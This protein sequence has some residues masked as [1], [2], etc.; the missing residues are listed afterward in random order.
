MARRGLWTPWRVVIVILVIALSLA[1]LAIPQEQMEA[2]QEYGYLGAFLISLLANATI[3]IPAPAIVIIFAMGAHLSPVW[4]GLA[5]GS[6]AA[7]G[8]LSGYLA[9]LSGQAIVEDNATYRRL[10]AWVKRYGG[11]AIFG[12]AAIPNPFF[13]LGGISAGAL[14]MPVLR[15]LLWCAAGKSLRMFVV[16]LAGAGLL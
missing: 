6:G 11:L 1:I 14:R 12:L 16:A 8:E 9:G 10:S 4:L 3:V 7:I 5:A 13:D 2:L 15:F